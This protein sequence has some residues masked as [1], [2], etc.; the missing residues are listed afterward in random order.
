M[1]TIRKFKSFRGMEG[2]GFNAELLQS[3]KPVAFVIDDAC[4]GCLEW[5][6]YKDIDVAKVKEELR[7]SPAFIHTRETYPSLGE[8]EAY[9]SAMIDIVTTYEETQSLKRWCKTKL[10]WKLP[11]DKKGQYGTWKV[12][13]TTEY[14]AKIKEKYPTAIIMNELFG[15]PVDEAI[16]KP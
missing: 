4:G 10:V 6:W 12:P 15:R 3:N 14:V 9:D 13:Y 8:G 5:Q 7:Q 11:T 2:Y 16:R 1:L